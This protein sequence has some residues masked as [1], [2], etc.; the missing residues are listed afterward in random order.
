[1]NKFFKLT[2]VT[3]EEEFFKG[4]VTSLNCETTEGRMGILAN[5]C[6]IIA[7]LVPTVTRFKDSN[8]KE[9]ETDTSD[10]II[11]VKDNEVIMLCNS[12][13]WLEK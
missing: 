4:D 5:H 2:I 12:A 7:G 8:E 11:K 3:P 9:Y 10:G 13:K 6:A 1:M